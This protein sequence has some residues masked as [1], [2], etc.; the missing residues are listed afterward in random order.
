[1]A[2]KQQLQGSVGSLLDTLA[3]RLDF[4]Q[5]AD[6]L[7]RWTA[8]SARLAAIARNINAWNNLPA[9]SL[10][11]GPAIAAVD[12]AARALALANYDDAASVRQ[13]L[14]A[15]ESAVTLLASCFG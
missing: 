4:S 2:T 12:A 11:F 13:A 7:S 1:M 10:Q 3:N 9:E 5:P 8:V 6:V 15:G 14:D